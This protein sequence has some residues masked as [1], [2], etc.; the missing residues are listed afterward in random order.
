MPGSPSCVFW[1][2]KPV[3]D[4]GPQTSVQDYV[5]PDNPFGHISTTWDDEYP[6]APRPHGDSVSNDDGSPPTDQEAQ[7]PPDCE[8][9]PAKAD[10]AQD[11]EEIGPCPASLLDKVK[12]FPEWITRS[13]ATR[14][15]PG[16]FTAKSLRNRDARGTGP[17]PFRYGPRGRE[18][19]TLGGLKWI[20][21]KWL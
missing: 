15:I 7:E 6:E 18:Y 9:E 16:L 20:S 19:L 4:Q 5:G 11:L 12:E 1:P 13:E 10:H 8:D 17:K 2:A 3:N 21:D 14:I